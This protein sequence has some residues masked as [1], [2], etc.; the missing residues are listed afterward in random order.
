MTK[1]VIVLIEILNPSTFQ[2]GFG[3]SYRFIDISIQ[4][5]ILFGPFH[6]DYYPFIEASQS[7]HPGTFLG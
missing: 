6:L 3:G 2:Q 7:I 4:N 5:L 1:R